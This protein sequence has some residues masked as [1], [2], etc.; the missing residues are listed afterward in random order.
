MQ[1]ELWDPLSGARRDLPTFESK[2]GRT[3]VPLEFEPDGSMFVVFRKSCPESGGRGQNKDKNF[4]TLNPAQEITGPWT[5]QF[6]PQWF[7]PTDGLSGDPAKGLMTFDKLEDWTQRSEPAV[8]HFSGTAVYRKSF[9]F[10]PDVRAQESGVGKTN[11]DLRSLTTD[12]S[13]R[14]YLDLGVVKESARVKLNGK[15]LGVVWCH[16]WRVEI[17][18]AVKPGE[19][20]LE[21]EVVNLWPNRLIGDSGLPEAQRRTRTNMPLNAKGKFLP[22]GLLGPVIVMK[23]Q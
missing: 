12:L 5:V 11:T 6:D 2:D 1:P 7:Y 9:D 4:I 15:D 3:T 8:K 19:N 16:P 13:A 22:S 18:K 23:K 20:Q 10:A 17:S 21:I 14:L